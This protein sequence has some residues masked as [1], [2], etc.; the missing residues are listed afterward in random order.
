MIRKKLE[1]WYTVE[2]IA[3]IMKIDYATA[4]QLLEDAIPYH[5][6]AFQR[7]VYDG[8]FEEFIANNTVYPADTH[9]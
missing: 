2:E 5:E 8:Y 6:I 7:R 9:K 4:L 3:Y 1:P